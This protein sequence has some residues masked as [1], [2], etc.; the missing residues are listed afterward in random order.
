[1]AQTVKQGNNRTVRSS[2]ILVP[3]E[4]AAQ[5]SQRQGVATCLSAP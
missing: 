1:M 5:S 4:G 2:W 3:E